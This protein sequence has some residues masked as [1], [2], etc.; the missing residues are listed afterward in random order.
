MEL[1]IRE[2][3]SGSHA[4]DSISLASITLNRYNKTQT[5]YQLGTPER[6]L[7]L[8]EKDLQSFFSEHRVADGRTA[9]TTSFSSTYNSYTFNNICRLISYCQHEKMA[10]LEKENK[11][12]IACD[13][14]AMTE[15]EWEAA[16]DGW[17]RVLLIPVVTS[18]NASGNQVSVTHDL[19][20]NSIR[21]IGGDTKLQMQVV[22][23]NFNP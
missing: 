22:Y 20:L 1:P 23:N 15:D 10:D 18:T 3:F 11:A 6:L 14:P 17:N 9:Y 7:M 4:T 19:S 8:R 21:L 5:S 12:R 16:H 2:I 13:Q